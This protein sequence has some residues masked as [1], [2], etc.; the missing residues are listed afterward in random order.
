MNEL[1]IK[2]DTIIHVI[3]DKEHFSTKNIDIFILF[4]HENII[5][6]IPYLP[7]Y[8]CIQ[9]PQLHTI[10]VLKFEHITKTRL[11]KYIENFTIQN[12]K[13]SNK[14]IWAQLFKAN[15]FVS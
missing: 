1:F 5:L 9:T 4:I 2:Q 10:L 15:D 6:W 13:F 14:K 12:W 11:F 8:I 3:Q 7:K